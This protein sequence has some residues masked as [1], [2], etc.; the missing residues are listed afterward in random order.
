MGRSATERLDARP[1]VVQILVG[2]QI[3]DLP[4]G[5]FHVGAGTKLRR[6]L[7]AAIERRRVDRVAARAQALRYRLPDR[8]AIALSSS[9]D[10]GRAHR[11]VARRPRQVEPYVRRGRKR[12]SRRTVGAGVRRAEGYGANPAASSKPWT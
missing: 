5:R 2:Q 12:A 1:D 8:A 10:G 7:A 6:A 11:N 9:S 3:D 4:G